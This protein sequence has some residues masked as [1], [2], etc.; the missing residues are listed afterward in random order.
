MCGTVSKLVRFSMV[1]VV[2]VAAALLCA[3]WLK[4]TATVECCLSVA[5]DGMAAALLCA[6]PVKSTAI[7]F[8]HC[9]LGMVLVASTFRV[10]V[11]SCFV[12]LET[13][14]WFSC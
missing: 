14:F 7:N 3:G 6:G 11:L 12:T 8:R 2:G 4:P 10:L 9:F 5:V 13:F 1:A